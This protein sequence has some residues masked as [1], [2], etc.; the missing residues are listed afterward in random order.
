MAPTERIAQDPDRREED[1]TPR[2]GKPKQDEA[3][4]PTRRLGISTKTSDFK[5]SGRKP[6]KL[7]F[8]ARGPYRVLEEAGRE[9]ILHTETPGSAVVDEATRKKNER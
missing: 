3:D 7:T 1:S 4:F 5:S 8:K 6:A 9:F 2:N